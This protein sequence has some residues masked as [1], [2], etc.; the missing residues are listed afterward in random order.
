L[1]DGSLEDVEVGPERV[2]SPTTDLLKMYLHE[3]GTFPLLTQREEWELARRAHQGDAE[4]RERL[5]NS[6]LRLVVSIAKRY[7]RYGV[8]LLDLIE[9]GNLG[10][11]RAVEKFKPQKG[12]RFST[13]ATWW[14]RQA[15]IRAVAAQSRTIRLPVHVVEQLNRFVSVSMALMQRLG[16]EPYAF[17]IAQR[18]K[19]PVEKIEEF[20]RIAEYPVSLETAIAG[21]DQDHELMAVIEDAVSPS[22]DQE[23]EQSLRKKIILELFDHLTPHESRILKYRFGIDEDRPHTLEETGKLVGVTRERIRQIE[24]AAL[25][26]LRDLIA[27]RQT[28]WRAWLE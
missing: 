7:S 20:Q 24:S 6:N 3:I 5:I 15:A 10:L 25:R 27:R 8:P 16:R 28:D 14:I 13:Y 12:F 21:E 4:A 2:Q 18:M 11:M 23:A 19:L 1:A 26:K 22:P 17:E 9:E